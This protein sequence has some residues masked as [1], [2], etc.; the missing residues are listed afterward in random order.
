MPVKYFGWTWI[1]CTL[2]LFVALAL[3]IAFAAPLI[4]S[5]E[6]NWV[7]AVL[8]LRTPVLTTVLQIVTFITSAV[9]CAIAMAALSAFLLLRQTRSL[10]PRR[11]L[12]HWRL[13]CPGLIFAGSIGSN[14]AMRIWVGRLPPQVEYLPALLPEVYASFHQ[15]SFP[16]G[17]A[18]TATVTYLAATPILL[19]IL[20]PVLA[21]RWHNWVRGLA[22]LI[23]LATGLGRVYMGVHWPTDVL[24]GYLLGLFWVGVGH[25]VRLRR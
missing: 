16:S 19:E 10:A 12:A 23:I 24:G 22:G 25:L 8:R 1:V 21:A 3:L 6:I 7:A 4:E 2:L 13:L 17:H 5:V 18:G 11:M 20:A 14:I 15:F 9:P